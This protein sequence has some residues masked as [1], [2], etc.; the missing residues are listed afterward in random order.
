MI[1]AEAAPALGDREIEAG[2][3]H[4]PFRI[5]RF[6][7]GGFAEQG[8]I[9]LNALMQVFD[10]Y[11]HVESFHEALLLRLAMTIGAQATSQTL[12]W[13]QFSV[14]YSTRPFIAG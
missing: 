9:E 6:D 5:I 12:P 11:V 14:R 1:D 4:H 2:I 10:R 7:H 13:Q 8:R 3:F